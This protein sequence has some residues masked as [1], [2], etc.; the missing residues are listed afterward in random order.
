MVAAVAA[1]AAI[2]CTPQPGLGTAT[3]VRGAVQHVLDLGTC[4]ERPSPAP[5][6]RMGA[7]VSPDGRLTADVRGAAGKQAIRVGGKTVLAL[8]RWSPNARNGSPGP[9]MLLGWSGDSRWIFYAIDPMGSQSI[10]A[11]GV[12]VRAVSLDGTS[13]AVAPALANDDYRAWCGGRLILTAGLDRIA[14]HN[15]RLVVAA[16]PTWTT[17][18]LVS[19]A[20]RAWG[21]L[22]CAPDGRSVVA[23][24]APDA[25]T[26]MSSVLAHWS[27]W[28][29][30]LDGSQRRLTSPPAG[31]SDDS[32]RYSGDGRTLFFVRS[33]T[34][35]G[36]LYAL[37]SGRLL[38]P[39]ASLGFQLGY[40]G[41]HAWPYTV[42][43]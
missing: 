14:A 29:V 38:G 4:R 39:F 3:Y 6:A 1:A 17:R 41:H 13:R 10:I 34:G 40:Y 33:R 31:Y 2:A 37:R 9:I 35:V 7:I 8:P 30:G 20:G 16:P 42:S 12:F 23:Q 28:R 26:D 43:P 5:A 36:R 27:L 15:K 25:G 21:S 11:D 22:A 24:S 32:P 19:A 18:A